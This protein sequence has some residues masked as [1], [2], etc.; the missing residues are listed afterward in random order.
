[1]RNLKTGEALH[2]KRDK[3][4][5]GGEAGETARAEKHLDRLAY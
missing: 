5:A 4:R 1:M 2:P 3:L